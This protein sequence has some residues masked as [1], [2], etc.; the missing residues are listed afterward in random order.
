ALTLLLGA[1]G[2]L[3]H[4]HIV[5]VAERDRLAAE[6][7][8]WGTDRAAWDHDR[9]ELERVKQELKDR[10]S[11]DVVCQRRGDEEPKTC[12]EALSQVRGEARTNAD[13][14]AKYREEVNAKVNE[15]AV[16]NGKLEKLKS[17]LN[18]ASVSKESAERQLR[19]E[20][21]RAVAQDAETK[22]L[23]QQAERLS[24]L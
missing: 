2:W 12:K 4:R 8:R 11:A 17:D 9:L 15:L 19:D 6:L 14:A 3:A 5:L 24:L 22:R 7:L 1:V 21:Q 16:A 18:V 20:Q 10:T 13:S 23:K